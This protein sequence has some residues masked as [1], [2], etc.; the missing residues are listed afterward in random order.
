MPSY[1]N[2]AQFNQR[3]LNCNKKFDA[4]FEKLEKGSN[5]QRQLQEVK[6]FYARAFNSTSNEEKREVII[7]E[8]EQFVVTVSDV[9]SGKLTAQEGLEIIQ[10]TAEERQSRVMIHNILKVCELFFWTTA[11][12]AAYAAGLSVGL[13]LL[14]LQP[15]LGFAVSA[16]TTILFFISLD[17]SLTCFEKFKSF[18]P[19]SEEHTREKDII[20]FFSPKQEEKVEPPTHTNLTSNFIATV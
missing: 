13:P 2:S 1:K 10:A 7:K 19:I 9:K 6:F 14:F 18:D 20:S 12:V 11:A 17:N 15:I 4:L 3:I 5:F 8:Y 16:G